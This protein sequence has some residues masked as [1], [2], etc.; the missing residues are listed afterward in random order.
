MQSEGIVLNDPEPMPV[1]PYGQSRKSTLPSH[2]TPS[3]FDQMQQ[4]ID[5]DRKVKS[6]WSKLT[7]NSFSNI[8]PDSF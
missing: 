1:D 5:M 7:R 3:S 2:T 4:F 8:K 6:L